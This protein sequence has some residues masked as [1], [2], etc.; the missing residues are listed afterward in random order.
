MGPNS[1][2]TG[3]LSRVEV[4]A[5]HKPP[6]IAEATNEWNYTTATPTRPHNMYR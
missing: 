4:A 3:V 5:V 1:V 2:R 6:S